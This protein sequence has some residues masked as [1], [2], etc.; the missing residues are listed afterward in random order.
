MQWIQAA[1]AIGGLLTIT[2]LLTLVVFDFAIPTLTLQLD[3]ILFLL[4]VAS[5]LLAIDL[6]QAAAPFDLDVS[7]RK[8]GDE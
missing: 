6:V 8:N 1:R 4:S 3:T 7:I 2:T 5:I